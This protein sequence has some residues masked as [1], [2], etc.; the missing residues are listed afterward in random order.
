MIDAGCFVHTDWG[1]TRKGSLEYFATN[2]AAKAKA[3]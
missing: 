3:A 1:G 2:T